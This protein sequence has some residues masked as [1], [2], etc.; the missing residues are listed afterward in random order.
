MTTAT[1]WREYELGELFNLSNGINA[2]KSAYGR[3][4]PFI[5]VLEVITNESLNASDIP[6]QV[7]LP[8][9]VLARY[10]VKQGDV[11]FNRT[12]ETQ[13]EV[14][15][16]SVYVDYHPVVFG[17]FVFR[18]RPT[19]S[20]LDVNY[21]KYALRAADVRHQIT[22]RGQGGIRANIGQRDL[23]SVVVRMPGK[24][25]QQAIAEVIDNASDLIRVLER[26]IAKKQAI[27]Q[28]M[29]Q[30]LLTGRTR[31]PGFSEKWSDSTLGAIARI[32][33]GGTPS[34]RVSSFWG[35]GV[36]WFTPAEIKAQGSGLV[37]SS[38]RTI[39]QEGLASSAATLLPAGTVLVTS[40]ASIGNCAVAAVPVS[41][42]QG[43]TSMV[44]KDSRSTWFLYY[45]IQQHRSELE[46]RAAGS[47]FLEISAS[48]VSAISL[49]QPD[50]DEQAAIGTAIRDADTELG[51]LTDRLTKAR[52]I[53]Q[54]MMQ[55]L[56]TGRVRLS[57]E[58]A[59]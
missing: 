51:A 9:K 2:D 37:S 35:G 48:K 1:E 54:G 10:Q 7:T 22:A 32:T 40:R 23:K 4:T 12:S 38:E 19:T 43:F 14:G 11:L 3:G 45:W 50:L 15:L 55:Q 57:V 29:M 59:S 27:K 18:G 26:L 24:P 34:T 49:R 28:G 36:P 17:G 56:L 58:V 53:K 13:D 25:E 52:A 44:P 6:G 5:N 41:T 42:N 16:T 46:S 39:T 30:Q 31:L 8:K 47:T 33:G 20:L 21:S